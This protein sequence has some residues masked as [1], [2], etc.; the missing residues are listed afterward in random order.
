MANLGTLTLDLICKTGSFTAPLDKAGRQAKRHMSTIEKSAQSASI[1]I[2]SMVSVGAI[3][4][5]TSSLISSSLEIQKMERLFNAAAGSANLGGRELEYVRQVSEKLGLNLATTGQ[6]YGKFMAAIRDTSL[7]GEAGRKVFESV[8]SAS[9][10]LGLSADE[11]HGIFNALQQ[12][13]SKGKVQAEEL[14]G[15]LGERLPAAMQLSAK[16][17]G[18]TTA[19]LNKMMEDGKLFANDL[20]PKLALELDKTY[21]GAAMEG[22]KSATAEINRFNNAMLETKAA[23]GKALLPAFTDILN[24]ANPVILS[25]QKVTQA[26]QIL[27]VRLGANSLKRATFWENIKSGI[28]AF[29]TEGLAKQEAVAKEADRLAEE[30][31]ALIL[32]GD[33]VE[34]SAY[35]EK[36]K[37]QQKALSTIKSLSSETKKIDKDTKSATDSINEQIKAL[38]FQA[39]MVGKSDDVIKLYELTNKGAT[40][41]QLA[42][43]DSA[44]TTIKAFNYQKEAAEKLAESQKKAD[45]DAKALKDQILSDQKSLISS[46]RTEEEKLTD[47]TKERLAVLETMKNLTD[48]ERSDV[49]KRIIASGVAPM[50]KFGGADS[51]IA[52]P[53]SELNKLEDATTA[54]ND[55]YTVQLEMLTKFRE[56][57]AELSAVWDQ[58]EIDLKKQHED[59]LARIESARQ[60]VQM[61]QNEAFFG[62]MSDLSKTFF[63][64]QSGMYKAMFAIEKAFAIA[65]V[66]LN[67]PSSYSKAYDAM[68][69]I[70]YVGPVLAPIAG[71]AAVA[72]QMAQAANLKSINF[73]GQA[74]DG[75]MSVPE[76]GTWNLKKGERVTTENTSAKLDRTLDNVQRSQQSNGGTVINLIED[77]SKAGQSEKRDDNG[78]ETIDIWVANLMGDGKVQKAM[79]RKFGL[80]PVGA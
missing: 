25:L 17:M 56:E 53:Q 12:M 8:A 36:E 69:G 62:S 30:Q 24:A 9:T 58:Q 27:G 59:E 2:G 49:A 50:P 63:G 48:S 37:R 11:T 41:S 80:Q 54:L 43:A 35:T 51:A 23:A 38:Q 57:K 10:A 29:S 28:G 18:V 65:K 67:A 44:L 45:E 71:T 34:S 52:G 3:T 21:G 39:E 64:E 13:M 78:K 55:W 79:T 26:V 61:A 46:L 76:S 66:L 16:A 47:Q 31:I 1:A 22:S 70:P 68:I 14:R 72:A 20:L 42:L 6:S 73:T 33:K 77:K 19:E 5:F 74:H 40:D 60:L 15:Q 4:A 32:K 7:E 75:I